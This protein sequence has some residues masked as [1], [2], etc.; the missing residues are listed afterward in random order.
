[1]SS[2]I[3]YDEVVR[4]AIRLIREGQNITKPAIRERLG[5]RGS[6]STIQ[7]HLDTWRET[8]SS[9]DVEV[10]PPSMPPELAEHLEA[11]WNAAVSLVEDN[12]AGE[13]DR[14]KQ[15]VEVAEAE[16]QAALEE[17]DRWQ[18]Y[19]Q[20][21][22]VELAQHVLETE[23]VSKQLRATE[24]RLQTRDQEYQALLD[25]LD[26]KDRMMADERQAMQERIEL[27]ESRHKQELEAA[28]SSWEAEKERLQEQAS[29]AQERAELE[30]RRSDQH[31][32][33]FLGE[34][35]KARDETDQ[36]RKE[37]EG[38]IERMEQE[39]VISQRREEASAQRLSKMEERLFEFE[40][41]YDEARTD[42]EK[43]RQDVSALESERDR[44]AAELDEEKRLRAEEAESREAS[45][46]GKDTGE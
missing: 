35:R 36:V 3:T 43:L 45:E 39:L 13:W 42:N 38:R 1:M 7:K 31:E 17:M 46:S 33:Y 19:V 25:R 41:R 10:L 9:S 22:D 11:F 20:E 29:T 34:V 5:N 6:H 15:S 23:Q 21:K 27:I 44:L 4:A 14:A 26:A 2:A 24:E 12:L 28:Q 30:V 32:V 8:L 18:E 37:A 40:R 16:K